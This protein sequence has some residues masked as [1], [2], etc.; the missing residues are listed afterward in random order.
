MNWLEIL[1]EIFRL[2]IVP[3]LAIL[4]RYLIVYIE[5]KKEDMIQKNQNEMADKYITM[6]AD[7]ISDCVR[8]TNQTYVDSLKQENVFDAEA[9]SEYIPPVDVK[10]NMASELEISRSFTVSALSDLINADINE[11]NYPI[12]RAFIDMLDVPIKSKI[13]EKL[14][15]KY[16][17]TE[18]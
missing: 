14:D 16:H 3:L 15:E 7:T 10:I 1:N 6:L 8:A 11:E 18:E 2:C 17:V 12:V 5:T 4:T 9:Q 13:Y